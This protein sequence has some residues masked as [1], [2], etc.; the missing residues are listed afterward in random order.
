MGRARWL[1]T[2]ATEVFF[3]GTKLFQSKDINL[4]RMVYMMVKEICPG[5]DEVRS[6]RPAVDGPRKLV[7]RSTTVATE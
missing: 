6:S 4:R 5:S 2:E 1:Q 7:F 3:A